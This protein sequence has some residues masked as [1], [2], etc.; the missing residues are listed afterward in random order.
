MVRITF[1]SWVLE[2][3]PEA[4]RGVLAALPA[5]GPEECG[6]L[7]CR[8][9]VLARATVYGP[10]FRA[11]LAALGVPPDRESEVYE[12]GPGARPGYR[13]YGGWFNA[14]GRVIAGPEGAELAGKA[15][16]PGLEVGIVPAKALV[17]D[18]LAGREVLEIGFHVQVPWLVPDPEPN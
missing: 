13:L 15:A 16:D 7:Y 12:N 3:D 14:V 11:L 5:G 6:C 8:N 17:P 9:F 10:R 1:A 2:C 18:A 4:T